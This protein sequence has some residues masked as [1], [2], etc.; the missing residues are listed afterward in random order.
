MSIPVE[1]EALPETIARY[2]PATFLL[3]TSDDGR[4]HATHV[5]VEVDGPRLRCPLGRRTARNGTAQPLVSLL[6]PPNEPGG[7]SLI[8]DGEIAVEPAVGEGDAHGVVTA[9]KAVLHR[10]APVEGAEDAACGSDCLT[11]DIPGTGADEPPAGS[12]PVGTT[13]SIS[14]NAGSDA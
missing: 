4:P 9:T 14:G 2:G 5:V 8:V 6:W 11:I 12:S 7:Y 1:V 3:T 13:S 10:P